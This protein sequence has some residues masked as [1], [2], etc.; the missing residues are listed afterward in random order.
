MKNW[1]EN[2]IKAYVS[3]YNVDQYG[4]VTTLTL[5]PLNQFISLMP[6]SQSI[7]Q[8]F[9]PINKFISLLSLSIINNYIYFSYVNI[10]IDCD[11]ISLKIL[12][13]LL[14]AYI[15]D[16]NKFMQVINKL[17]IPYTYVDKKVLC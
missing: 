10:I 7:D 9:Q 13:S 3:Q 11:T 4:A 1:I 15:K 12:R 16:T 2:V 6:M 5:T 14:I 17:Y 8:E